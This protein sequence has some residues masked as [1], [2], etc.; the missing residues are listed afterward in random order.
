MKCTQMQNEECKMQN[1]DR[2]MPGLELLSLLASWRGV[3]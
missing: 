3:V 2:W 1:E